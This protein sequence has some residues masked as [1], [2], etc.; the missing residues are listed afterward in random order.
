MKKEEQGEREAFLFR[1]YRC[2]R[3]QQV[4][5]RR[6]RRS[7]Q[8]PAAVASV[9]IT[10]SYDAIRPGGLVA[11]KNRDSFGYQS[12]V[13]FSSFQVRAEVPAFFLGK[14]TRAAPIEAHVESAASL[15][16]SVLLLF[17]VRFVGSFLMT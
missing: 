6:S 13:H 12:N 10:A 7:A 11:A 17:S 1:K 5:W 2:Y 8:L 14:R 9:G 15:R 4:P 16:Q 3:K